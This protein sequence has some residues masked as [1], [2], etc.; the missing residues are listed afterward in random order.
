MK[1]LSFFTGDGKEEKVR[2]IKKRR[3]GCTGLKTGGPN[4]DSVNGGGPILNPDCPAS[5]G[6]CGLC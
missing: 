2:F 4:L 3:L 5:F 1:I 6:K